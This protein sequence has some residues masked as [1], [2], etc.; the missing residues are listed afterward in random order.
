MVVWMTRSS[1]VWID[2]RSHVHNNER[3]PNTLS[4]LKFDYKLKELRFTTYALTLRKS[5]HLL[6]TESDL[7]TRTRSAQAPRTIS[8]RSTFRSSYL[9]RFPNL[10]HA[11]LFAWFLG[12]RPL[13]LDRVFLRVCESKSAT[14][15]YAL[16]LTF[17]P[18]AQSLF[19]VTGI[20][21]L[22]VL[23]TVRTP[24]ERLETVSISW[25]TS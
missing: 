24:H 19:Q 2:G 20:S 17:M 23:R 9:A 21:M 7:L 16:S 18:T 22:R 25:G 5:P 13:L 3:T 8:S 12:R 10:A 14:P 1:D 15:S 6:S 11:S 4:G